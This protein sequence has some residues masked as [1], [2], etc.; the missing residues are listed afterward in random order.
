MNQPTAFALVDGNNF[1]VS[2][3]RVF[4]PRLEGLPVVVLSNND[5]CAVA[6][7]NEAKA[8]GIG[9]GQ[10]WYQCRALARAHGIV[11]LSS[12][13]TLYADMSQRMMAILGGF[14]PRIE[15]YSIDE[16]FLDVSA[17]P[18]DLTALGQRIRAQV[19][20]WI[21][22]PTC[23]GIGPTKTLAKLANH[24]AKKRPA[25]AGVCDLTAQACSEMET[26]MDS[27]P[28]GEV[29][30]IGRR[31]AEHLQGQGITTAKALRDL[32]PALARRR[33][34]VVLERT[35]LELRGISCL[36]LEPTVA[37]KKNIICSRSFGQPVTDIKGLRQAIVT[38]ASRAAEKLRRQQGAAQA[39]EVFI[40]TSRFK[41]PFY[42]P[43]VRIGLANPSDDSRVLVKAALQG[44]ER[45]YRP[46]WAYV[47]AGVELQA[48]QPRDSGWTADLLAAPDPRS[49][50]LMRALDAINRRMGAGTLRLAGAGIDPAW[51][52]NRGKLSPAYTT[53]LGE[54]PQAC[55]VVRPCAA[56]MPGSALPT[57]CCIRWGCS[58]TARISSRTTTPRR[59]SRY[60]WCASGMRIGKRR[61]CAGG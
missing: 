17:L 23:V 32:D 42:G 15:V 35:V 3:E 26:L 47:K 58:G 38:Y 22:I 51:A 25:W 27:I 28:V 33:H 43:C 30:G 50:P 39:I 14:A 41:S 55:A 54:L 29:W 24:I 2:C 1:Y 53:R 52:M 60:W 49:A 31:L 45:I 40:Q 56:A 16:A 8:L 18:E 21:G 20:Q 7:S 57:G 37:P 36:P 5:G 19:H 11:A 9:M 46:G 6:R 44:L 59:A 13:Y 10:P 12:N 48:I 4:N 34:S 61:C